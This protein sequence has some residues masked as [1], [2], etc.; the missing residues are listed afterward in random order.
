MTTFSPSRIFC[1]QSSA[2]R[3]AVR[4][5]CE[6]AGNIRSDS[7]TALG[8]SEGSSSSFWRSSGCSI[9]ARIPEQ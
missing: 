1:P 8:I 4:R 7:S 5:K 6:K 9:S 2:S 3:V